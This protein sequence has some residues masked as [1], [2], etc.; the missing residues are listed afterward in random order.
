MKLKVD[1][2]TVKDKGI[3]YLLEL[4]LEGK[5]LV[6][7]GVTSRPKIEDRVCEILVSMFKFYRCFPYIRP[8]RFKTTTSIYKK[9]AD[10]HRYFKDRQYALEHKVDGH[11]E[12]FLIP[13]EEAVEV[14]ERVLNGEDINEGR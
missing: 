12:L 11:S 5:V 10:L 14:Y 2:D 9:E 8:K 7:I 13:L 4:H 3:V 1:T 6:K